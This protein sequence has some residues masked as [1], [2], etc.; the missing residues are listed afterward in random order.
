MNFP[1]LQAA[2][3]ERY[4]DR[5]VQ[6]AKAHKVFLDS[7]DTPGGFSLAHANP[8]DL[9]LT[10][11]D[12]IDDDA[13]PQ[14][15][16]FEALEKYAKSGP[17][18][19]NRAMALRVL[20]ELRIVFGLSSTPAMTRKTLGNSGPDEDLALQMHIALTRLYFSLSELLLV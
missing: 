6:A 5:L 17:V 13:G 2:V 16:A 18:R 9:L 10:Y 20:C 1:E 4:F 3:K 7:G 15:D 11:R 14:T 19:D 12:L 8:R